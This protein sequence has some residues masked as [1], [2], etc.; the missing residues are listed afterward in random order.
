MARA[1]LDCQLLSSYCIALPVTIVE[2]AIGSDEISCR[3]GSVERFESLTFETLTVSAIF[4]TL[5]A[6]KSRK[7]KKVIIN[8]IFI[9][10]III[11]SVSQGR[12]ED[13]VTYVRIIRVPL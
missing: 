3:D 5:F 9:I 10:K 7:L 2:I 12:L 6:L 1:A 13:T 8:N 11:C 4:F